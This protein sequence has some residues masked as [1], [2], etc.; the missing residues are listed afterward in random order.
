MQKTIAELIAWV[1]EVVPNKISSTT[2]QRFISDQLGDSEFRRYNTA[3]TWY[4][5]YTASG[6]S[7]Y[8]LPSGVRVDDLIYLGISNTTYNSTDVLASSTPYVEYKYAGLRDESYPCYTDYTTKLAIKPTPQDAYHMRMI[9]KP[10][11]R[12][13]PAATSD[14]TTLIEAETPLIN[15]LQYKI[16]ARVCKS[17]TFPR[18]DLGN[19]YELDAEASMGV[20]RM[21]YYN[22]KR[23]ESKTNI[24]WKDW[25]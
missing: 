14:S 15:W 9:Y 8:N 18:I 12:N 16:A 5:T 2:K 1:D 21:N 17:M 4:D 25:W 19:N 24:G 11:Y 10:Q 13:L 23:R 6:V 7:E 20:A 3:K 22:R